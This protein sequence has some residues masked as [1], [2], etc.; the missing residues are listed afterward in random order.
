MSG[1]RHPRPWAGCAPRAR[2]VGLDRE[3]LDVE[4]EIV[5]PLDALVDAPAL[6]RRELFG[7]G[8]LLPE[9]AVLLHDAVA[10]LDRVDVFVEAAAGLQVEQ[11]AGDVDTRDLEVVLAL[12][13]REPVVELA[14]LGVDEVG[15]E[16][17]GVASEQRVGERHVTPEESDDVQAHEQHGERVDQAG[18]GIRPQGLRVQRAV[19]QRELEVPGDE[20]R[21][22]RLARLRGAVG[23]HGD[24]VDARDVE[25]LQRAQHLVFVL[26]QLG[27]GLLD[28]DDVAAEV[29]EPHE[30]REMPLG[31]AAMS[32]RARPRAAGSTAGR[33]G[34]GRPS[35]P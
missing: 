14:G 13:V 7:A 5:E 23:D 32:R 4:T 9:R 33:A 28:R 17:A 15:R 1:V 6:R 21:L 25:A 30:W 35:P 26:G 10:D 19:G 22:E 18:R 29:H 3:L 24:R 31:R 20:H 34:R 16:R 27:G 8:Q 12:A 11:L 2:L